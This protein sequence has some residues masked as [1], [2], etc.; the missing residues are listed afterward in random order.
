MR[1]CVGISPNTKRPP[2]EKGRANTTLKLP[3]PTSGSP[4][5][6]VGLFLCGSCFGGVGEWADCDRRKE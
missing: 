5:P 4:P 1:R 2:N 6:V 3:V